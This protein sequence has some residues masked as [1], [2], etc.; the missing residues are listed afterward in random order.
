MQNLTPEEKVIAA[1]MMLLRKKPFFGYILSQIPIVPNNQKSS[2]R[3]YIEYN[4]EFFKELSTEEVATV[5]VHEC[6][7]YVLGHSKRAKALKRSFPD[8]AGLINIAEDVVINAILNEN[9]FRKL[10]DGIW[11]SIEKKVVLSDAK[12]QVVIENPH[13]KS[14]E[15][16]FHMI[17]DLELNFDP[18]NNST[19]S[20]VVKEETESDSITQNQSKLEQN[21]NSQDMNELT[22]NKMKSPEEMLNSAY[23]YACSHGNTPLGIDRRVELT[24]KPLLN[25]KAILKEFLTSSIPYNYSF[26]EPD[27]DSPPNI[28]MPGIEYLE[29]IDGILAID[30][31]GSITDQM[32][33]RFLT[34]VA[35]LM[36]N[37]PQM[38][39]TV[40]FCDAEIQAIE[41]I[42][43]AKEVA[44]IVPKGGGGTDFRPVFE[45]ARKKKV[46]FV[47]CLTD[48]YAV[49]PPPE[50][51]VKTLWIVTPD[52]LPENEFPFGRVVR[53][54]F[55]SVE[56]A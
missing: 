21:S 11:P 6:M 22:K 52:G 7:H 33:S 49:F 8:K 39:I 16:V 29:Q 46:R 37:F 28:I 26:L 5:L 36:R 34:E 42:K 56:T 50:K 1:K 53:L 38:E 14:V 23:T 15:E 18:E 41:K 30:T 20:L 12:K 54:C 17:K 25:W 31:S 43:N 19:A 48:G 9:G 2:S 27:E 55:P 45:F 40:V 35:G 13:E 4:P 47:I 10:K 24:M 44:K 32:L 51:A 3:I